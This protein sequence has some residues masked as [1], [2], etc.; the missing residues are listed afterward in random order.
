MCGLHMLFFLIKKFRFLC[1]NSDFCGATP[2]PSGKEEK[3]RLDEMF[4]IFVQL[5]IP[6]LF[7]RI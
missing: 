3:V 4:L 1:A 7:G 2:T 5:A 6:R